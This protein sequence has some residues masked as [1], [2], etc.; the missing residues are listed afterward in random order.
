MSEQEMKDFFEQIEKYKLAIPGYDEFM[1]ICEQYDLIME[2]Y[3]PKPIIIT[4]DRTTFDTNL[5]YKHNESV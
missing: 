2:W 5:H 4:T 1:K 3:R